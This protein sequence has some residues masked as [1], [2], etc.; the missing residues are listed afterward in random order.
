MKLTI[1][2]EAHEVEQ[3]GTAEQ[4]VVKVVEKEIAKRAVNAAHGLWSQARCTCGHTRHWHGQKPPQPRGSGA[5]DDCACEK[6]E[7]AD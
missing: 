4:G 1:D 5:C 6:F 7:R 2:I 3:L